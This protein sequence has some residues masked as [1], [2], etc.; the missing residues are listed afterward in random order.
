MGELGYPTDP[1]EFSRRSAAVSERPEDAVLVA[2]ENGNIVGLVALHSFEMIHRPGRLGRV[3]ALVVAQSARGRGVG[4]QLLDAAE[5]HLL[6]LGCTRLEVTSGPG[7]ID[8]HRFY[9]SHGYKEWRVRFIKD[10]G[11]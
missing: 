5:K 9:E 1:D 8:A 2:E 3:T 6:A 7:R 4:G 11:S 10:P